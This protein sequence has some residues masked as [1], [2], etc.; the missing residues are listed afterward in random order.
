M[1]RS[2]FVQFFVSNLSWMGASVVLA[3]MI[4]IAANMADDPVIQD[5][6]DRVAVQI[7]LPEGFVVTGQPEVTTVTAVIRASRTQWDLLTPDSVL[8]TA[9]LSGYDQPGTYRVELEAD[10][11]APL[12]GRVVALRPTV[13]SITMDRQVEQRLPIQVIVTNDPPLGYTYPSELTCAEFEVIVQGSAERV[14]S[15]QQ[16]EARLNL[17]DDVNPVTRNVNLTAVQSNGLRARDVTL[18]PA[19][20]TCFVDIQPR[21]DVFQMPV[22]PRVAGS[23]PPGYDFTGYSDIEP[24]TVPLTG[25]LGAIRSLPGLIRTAPIDL[26]DR[27]ET[28]TIEVPLDLP[29]GV[30]T[31]PENQ[32]IQV[33]VSIEPQVTTRPFE[34]VPVEVV[35]LDTTQ[36]RAVGLAD[37]VTVFISAPPGHLP[38]PEGVRAIVDLT[39]LAPGV[40]A[41][42]PI[43]LIEGEEPTEDVMLTISP[44]ELNVT[45]EAINPTPP[46]TRGPGEP[47]PRG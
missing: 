46:P 34:D 2:P 44:D 6:L 36:F 3:L 12:R 1:R 7:E 20:I 40:H 11:I 30:T 31:V 15:V 39:G 17:S 29:E 41:V 10:V 25:D 8:V 19:S 13:W 9:N 42:K 43:G 38:P 5:E 24:D 23:P 32:L 28:F 35:G 27:T 16:V 14:A 45:I 22:L 26:M 37:T 21:T 4:W 33:T 47:T 18:I